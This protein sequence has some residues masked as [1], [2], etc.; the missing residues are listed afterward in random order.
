MEEAEE[1]VLVELLSFLVQD[2]KENYSQIFNLSHLKHWHKSTRE[3][4]NCSNLAIINN[5]VYCKKNVPCLR[6]YEDNYIDR[7]V[8]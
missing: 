4:S 6:M 2:M 7:D 5:A 3:C 1:D 8:V